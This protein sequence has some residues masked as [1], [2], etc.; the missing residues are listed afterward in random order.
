MIKYLINILA[1][2]AY[3]KGNVMERH[4]ARGDDDADE[5]N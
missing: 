2:S 3:E 5:P 4:M 1:T